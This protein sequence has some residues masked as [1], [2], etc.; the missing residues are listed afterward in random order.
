MFW[1]NHGIFVTTKNKQ[2][3]NDRNYRPQKELGMRFELTIT[4]M[5][6]TSEEIN[7]GDLGQ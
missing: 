5:I 7:A 1:C 3:H 6:D 2:Y 4:A